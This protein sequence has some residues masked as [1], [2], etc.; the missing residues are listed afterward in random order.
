MDYLIPQP[1]KPLPRWGPGIITFLGTLMGVGGILRV[2]FGEHAAF[3]W[4]DIAAIAA[5]GAVLYRTRHRSKKPPTAV[6]PPPD[7]MWNSSI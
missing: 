7:Q 2:A 4:A 3:P 1:P 6:S 5:T